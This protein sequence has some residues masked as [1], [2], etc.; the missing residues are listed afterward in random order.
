MCVCVC[1]CVF[2]CVC[3]PVCVIDCICVAPLGNVG[4]WRR[5]WFI[6]WLVHG[7]V[8]LAMGSVGGAHCPFCSSPMKIGNHA[9]AVINPPSIIVH[10]PVAIICPPS[11]AISYVCRRKRKLRE[12]W[13]PK[14][15]IHHHTT[16]SNKAYDW[17]AV[18]KTYDYVV[19]ISFLI[20]ML[21]WLVIMSC[22]D[23]FYACRNYV[24]LS[25]FLVCV[26][27]IVLVVAMC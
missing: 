8:T 1:L 25:M 27:V 22:G 16:C 12:K 2:A 21:Y 24:V 3:L 26:I 7:C 14:L 20:M 15:S 18:W 13:H 11:Y 10:H 5:G 6:P 19:V 4:A 23:V 9:S 17:E